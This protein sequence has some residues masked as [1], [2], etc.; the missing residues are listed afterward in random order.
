MLAF[1]P[2]NPITRP[3]GDRR[4]AEGEVA[5]W[6]LGDWQGSKVTPTYNSAVMVERVMRY[7][8]KAEK[9]TAVQRADHPVREC[10]IIF[11]GDMLEGLFNYPSQPYEIDSTLFGQYVSVSRLLVD[12]VRFAGTIYEKVTIVPEWGNHGRL[13]SKRAAVV[14]S[15]NADRMCFE[16]GRQLLEG[17]SWLSWPDCPDD[18]QRLEVGKYRAIVLHGDEVGRNGFASP[19]SMVAY[20]TRQQS[21]AYGWQF[22]DAYVHHYHVHQE[23]SLP[24]GLGR[25]FYN[26]STESDNRYARDTMAS[27]ATPSQR[28]QFVHPVDARVTA[29]YKVD[30]A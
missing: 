30:L 21:G 2:V 1:G 14:K 4:K 19:T 25:V 9:I 22:H 23:F 24:N 26:G 15:D 18:I 7:C 3:K 20:I 17:E 13:G 11:G 28:L 6:D 29:Q 27:A 16:L 8:T 12:V 10:V 5:I